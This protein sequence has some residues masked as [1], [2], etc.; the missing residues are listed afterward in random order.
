MLVYHSIQ[1]SHTWS[2][3]S[4]LLRVIILETRILCHFIS[5]LLS[6]TLIKQLTCNVSMILL[7]VFLVWIFS[8]CEFFQVTET[9]ARCALYVIC[10][11]FIIFEQVTLYFAYYTWFVAMLASPYAVLLRTCLYLFL[12]YFDSS[13]YIRIQFEFH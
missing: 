8:W 1:L 13:V 6:S 4:R 11:Q 10:Y 3:F 7:Y 5:V 9:D 12:A 2:D